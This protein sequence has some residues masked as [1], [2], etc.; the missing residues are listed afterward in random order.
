MKC[1]A[2]VSLARALV[3]LTAGAAV[4]VL[5]DSNNPSA[6]VRTPMSRVYLTDQGRIFEVNTAEGRLDAVT[7]DIAARKIMIDGQNNVYA[8][9][10]RYDPRSDLYR[11]TM[12]R[13]S[14]EGGGLTEAKSTAAGDFTFSDV[15]DAEGNLY[16]WQFDARK[17]TSRIMLRSRS[18]DLI[19]LAGG[20]WGVKDGR[21]SDALLSRLGSMTVDAKGIVFFTDDQCVRRLDREGN[22]TTLAVGGQLALGAGRSPSNHLSAIAVDDRDAVYVGDAVT[23]RIMLVEPSGNVSTLTY[24]P[25]EWTPVSLA[26]SNGALYVLEISDDTKRVVRVGVDGSRRELPRSERIPDGNGTPPIR[27]S[28]AGTAPGD[29]RAA[30]LPMFFMPMTAL[31]HLF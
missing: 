23:H 21:G 26:W 18:G 15:A 19:S 7:R 24:S 28:E 3:L 14:A 31:P 10:L 17:Q 6:L 11:P 12:W 5:A 8:A 4:T 20:K 29:S 16:F 1:P 2:S 9:A 30:F 22:V 13:Y 25:E 27:L